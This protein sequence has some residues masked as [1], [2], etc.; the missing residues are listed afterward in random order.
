MRPP[1]QDSERH[2]EQYLMYGTAFF[3]N[4]TILV[5]APTGVGETNIAILQEVAANM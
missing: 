2:P 5:R 3:G 4:K 1:L